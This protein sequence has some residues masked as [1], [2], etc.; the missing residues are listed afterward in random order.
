MNL[1]SHIGLF[2]KPNDTRVDNTLFQLHA[3]LIQQGFEVHCDRNAG[4]ILGLP[5]MPSDALARHIDLAIVV[6]GDGTLLATGRLLADHEVPLIGINLG[7]LGFLVDISPD[8]M[9]TQVEHIL[10]GQ[11][12]E[13]TRFV[14]H[15]DA[16]RDDE[17]LGSGDA[18]NDVVLH[19]RNEIR[20]IEFTTYIDGHFVNTQRADG[21]VVTTPTGSTAYALSSGGPIMHP[22]LQA[23]ALVPICP[24]TL[25][26]RPL[27]ISNQSVIEITLCEDRDIPARLSFD[28][29]NNIE[30]ESG[31]LIRIHTRP[32]K[33]RLL[34]PQSYD[35]YHI[36]REKL[37]WGV[38]P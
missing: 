16:I 37:H 13:E 5:T 21:L 32:E 23:I 24:H 26:D 18:L 9:L 2:T 15:A 11:Y 31:D 20:M 3:F 17:L 27:V 33:V 12:K 38:Q 7:R 25:T 8:E 28:G 36:L 10:S 19:V 22:A 35:Y 4:I 6:G 34:H 1:F 30:L 14:L 29:Q